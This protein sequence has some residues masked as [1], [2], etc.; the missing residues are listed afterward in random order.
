MI[1]INRSKYNNKYILWY[2]ILKIK[3][4]STSQY[5]NYL[6]QLY[7]KYIVAWNCHKW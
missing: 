5:N 4:I 7:V 1:N 2:D 3:N 6:I